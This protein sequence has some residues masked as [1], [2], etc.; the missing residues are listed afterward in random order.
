LQ[1]NFI[2]LPL[3]KISYPVALGIDESVVPW[4]LMRKK[5]REE[6]LW[7]AFLFLFK[8]KKKHYW[9]LLN[10]LAKVKSLL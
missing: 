4:E 10:N 2:I 7:R 5:S 8:K 9:V 3:F 1:T 6:S